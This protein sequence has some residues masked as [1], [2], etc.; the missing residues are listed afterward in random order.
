MAYSPEK[1]RGGE[2]VVKEGHNL[3]ALTTY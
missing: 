3:F 1:P 2:W